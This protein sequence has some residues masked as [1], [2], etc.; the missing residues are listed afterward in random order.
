[1]VDTAL[2]G[3]DSEISAGLSTVII[4]ASWL[5]SSHLNKSETRLFVNQACKVAGRLVRPDLVLINDKTKEVSIVDVTFPFENGK[6]ALLAARVRKAEK[7]KPEADSYTTQGYKVYCGA[8]V[9]GA[10]GTWDPENSG[11]LQAL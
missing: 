3:L 5:P 2:R 11:A 10:L 9:V 1:M 8:I 6:D 4:I 7:Y